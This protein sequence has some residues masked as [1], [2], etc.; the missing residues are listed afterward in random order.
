MLEIF[1]DAVKQHNAHGFR[2]FL[3]DNSADGSGTHQEIFIEYVAFCQ[4]AECSQ[5]DSSAKQDIGSKKYH[6][7]RQLHPHML[8]HFPCN[9]KDSAGAEGQNGFGIL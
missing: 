4:V 3:D 8:Q 1:S 2:I 5:H 9:E 6:E 7:G